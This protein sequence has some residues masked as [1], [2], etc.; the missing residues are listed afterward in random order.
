M[1]LHVVSLCDSFHCAAAL[2][3]GQRSRLKNYLAPA[4]RCVAFMPRAGSE[5]TAPSV[6][7]IWAPTISKPVSR[8]HIMAL[9]SIHLQ[10]YGD[11]FTFR[12]N[13]L[14]MWNQLEQAYC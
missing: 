1:I 5:I 7:G 13:L 10:A 11:E 3:G 4:P 8:A 6:I 14:T 2:P 12:C 9:V